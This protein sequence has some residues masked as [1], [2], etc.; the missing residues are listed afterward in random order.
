[1]KVLTA[2]TIVVL[3][4]VVPGFALAAKDQDDI[5]NREISDRDFKPSIDQAEKQLKLL[6]KAIDEMQRQLSPME[7]DIKENLKRLKLL[8]KLAQKRYVNMQKV[9]TEWD[10]ILKDNKNLT[11]K[12]GDIQE[13][14]KDMDK[15]FAE[16]GKAI[17]KIGK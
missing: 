16:Y 1:M 2:I 11:T 14:Y 5:D 6:Q 13:A 15:A 12:F 17:I 7:R 4:L 10:A 8:E 3:L 9:N